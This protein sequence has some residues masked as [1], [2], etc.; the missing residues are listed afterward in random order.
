MSENQFP[1]IYADELAGI[2]LGFPMSKLTF[3]SSRQLGSDGKVIKTNV[4]T[5]TISTQSLIKGLNFAHDYVQENKLGLLASASEASENISISI[6]KNM[7]PKVEKKVAAAK[8]SP[9]LT[10]G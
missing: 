8:K 7:T 10:K 3:T 2:M 4:L 1:E 6:Q 9:A 5:V